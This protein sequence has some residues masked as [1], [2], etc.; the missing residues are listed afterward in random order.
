VNGN[1][2]LGPEA[3]VMGDIAPKK[4]ELIFNECLNFDVLEEKKVKQ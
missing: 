3:G 1:P 4:L 2:Q